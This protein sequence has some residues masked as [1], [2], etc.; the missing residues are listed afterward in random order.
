MRVLDVSVDVGPGA[1]PAQIEALVR[2]VRVATDVGRAAELRRVRRSS[3]ERL[4]FPTDEE[5]SNALERLPQGS[6][7]SPFYR[8]QRLLEVRAYLEQEARDMPPDLWWDYWYRRRRRTKGAFSELSGTGYERAFAGATGPWLGG[9]SAGLDVLDPELYLALI[10][11]EVARLAPAEVTVRELRYRNP[12]GEELAAVGAGAE[13]L[14]KVAGV[15]ETAA[16][17]GDRKK[18]KRA[19]AAVAEATVNDRI[20]TSHLD[21]EL[22][23]EQLRQAKLA[24]EIAEQELLANRIQNAQ[25]LEALNAQRR[26]QALVEHFTAAGQLDEA[27][28]IAALQ[29]SDASALGE[30]ALRQPVL[31]QAVEPDPSDE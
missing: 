22:K 19:E 13:A 17:L 2:A 4:K 30:F 12:F 3:S 31:T 20:D 5:L 25:A 7:S 16:T 8:A 26:Q 27:D 9:I 1:T 28:A 29:P 23:Q 21:V 18:I 14:T 11:D 10:A 15:I 6:E 24:N